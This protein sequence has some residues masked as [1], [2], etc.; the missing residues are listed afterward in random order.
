MLEGAQLEHLH[1]GEVAGVYVDAEQVVDG[2]CE[3]AL[4]D[5][6][7]DAVQDR[8]AGASFHR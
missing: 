5:V 3:L 6:V 1:Q 8:V 4:G 7:D 2:L